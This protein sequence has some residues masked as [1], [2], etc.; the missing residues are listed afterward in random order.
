MPLT[1]I[2]LLDGF[3]LRLN[4]LDNMVNSDLIVKLGFESRI[5]NNFCFELTLVSLLD[6]FY[7]GLTFK[8]YLGLGRI[9]LKVITVLVDL[10]FRFGFFRRHVVIV[11]RIC[12]IAR[13]CALIR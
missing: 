5:N 9:N 11:F 2:P 8:I 1:T 6:F 12:H 10:L 4:S 7:Q 13:F 3:S